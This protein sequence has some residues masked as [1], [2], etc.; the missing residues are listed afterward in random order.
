MNVKRVSFEVAMI[1]GAVTASSAITFACAG[2]A[3][4]AIAGAICVAFVF[5][6]AMI[7]ANFE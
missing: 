2:E 7:F 3:N 1:V 5:G 4:K 6:F